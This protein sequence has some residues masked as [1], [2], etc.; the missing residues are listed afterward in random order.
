MESAVCWKLRRSRSWKHTD[1]REYGK[2]LV[3]QAAVNAITCAF[4][5]HSFNRGTL[6]L[7]QFVRC[8]RFSRKWIDAQFVSPSQHAVIGTPCRMARGRIS[9]L[10]RNVV[11]MMG[12][13][14]RL[15]DFSLKRLSGRAASSC[16]SLTAAVSPF[17]L[18]EVVVRLHFGSEE[19]PN[20]TAATCFRT[21]KERSWL[22]PIFRNTPDDRSKSICR[23]SVCLEPKVDYC[24][25][26]VSQRFPP[27][28]NN[29]RPRP[30]RDKRFAQSVTSHWE[31]W[32]SRW[33]SSSNDKSSTPAA[34]DA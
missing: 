33:L 6:S 4:H 14:S 27:A 17:L 11:R 21:A 13:S 28:R 1:D 2:G 15:G 7:R 20:G 19:T 25:F 3:I 31:A 32:D 18:N 24:R 8:F 22:G 12:R 23:L 26:R 29:L 16:S 34:A 9:R 10:L 5:G 30:S